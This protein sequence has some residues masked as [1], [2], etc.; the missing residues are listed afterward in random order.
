MDIETR[1]QVRHYL[2][3]RLA[4]KGHGAPIADEQPLFSSGLLDSLDAVELVVYVEDEF[5]INFSEINFDLTLLDSIAAVCVLVEH[6]QKQSHG[7]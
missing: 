6:H 2:T 1:S 7:A 3:Q 5:G 4:L